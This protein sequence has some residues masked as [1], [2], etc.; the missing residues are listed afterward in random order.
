MRMN[1]PDDTIERLR[2]R[3]AGLTGPARCRPLLEVAQAHASR[4]WRTGLGQPTGETDLDGA[5][6]ALTEARDLMQPDDPWRRLVAYDL[7]LHRGS[8]HLAHG[9]PDTDREAAVMLLEEA[10]TA[11][12]PPAGVASARIMIAQLSLSRAVAGPR[13]PADLVSLMPSPAPL[14]GKAH[15]D[16]AVAELR[17]VLAGGI[18]GEISRGVETLLALA[19]TLQEWYGTHG[20]GL[21]IVRVATLATKLQQTHESIRAAGGGDGITTAPGAVPQHSLFDIDAFARMDPLD[22]PVTVVHSTEEP[23]DEAPEPPPGQHAPEPPGVD[24]DALRFALLDVVT[25]LVRGIP[26][27][28]PPEDSSAVHLAVSALL[29]PSTPAPA[30]DLVDEFVAMATT[31]VH[32]GGRPAPAVAGLDRFVLAV[33]LRLRARL[34]RGGWAEDELDGAPAAGIEELVT[35]AECLPAE[36]PAAATVIGALGAFLDPSDPLGHGLTDVADRFAVRARALPG[37]PV[38]AALRALCRAATAPRSRCGAAAETLAER[39]DAVP[40]HYPWR[41]VLAVAVDAARRDPAARRGAGVLLAQGRA[42]EAF[43]VLEAAAAEGPV[44]SV[45]EVAAAVR[46]VGADALVHQHPIGDPQGRAGVL[47]VTADGLRDL[48]TPDPAAVVGTVLAAVGDGP[49]RLLVAAAD[50]PDRLLWAEATAPELVVSFVSS[51]RQVVTLTGRRPPAVTDAVVFVANPLGDR[52]TATVEAMVLRRIFHPHSIGLGHT[53]EQID[54]PGT[55]ADVLARL[56][57]TSLLHLGCGI[58]DSLQLAG[59]S[60]LTPEEIRDAGSGGLVVLPADSA[61]QPGTEALAA[62]FLDAGMTGV[63]GWLRPV[64]APAASA[65]MFMLHTKLVDEGLDP[66]AAVHAVRQWTRDPHRAVPPHLPPGWNVTG[67]HWSALCHLGR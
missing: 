26:G 27:G 12:L 49:R 48:G 32:G 41:Q 24:V 51:G 63:V 11:E 10:L 33:A 19:E 29:E 20:A 15:A 58:T 43:A 16:R 56:P 31:V 47:L 7:G 38:A 62:A 37:D 44:A 18:S 25:H 66:A 57:G 54:G 64:P 42:A 40:E 8:R 21:D 14:P 59:P 30:P 53:V 28:Q 50:V 1:T 55:A 35:A 23:A 61:G 39:I 52:D 13:S 60:R 2:A 5:I 9:G 3:L 6:A 4:Y 17:L 65:M 67:E 34:D 45:D 46:A 22:Q 36:H